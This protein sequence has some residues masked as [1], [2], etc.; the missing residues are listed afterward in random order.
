[1]S[2]KKF[3]FL[4]DFSALSQWGHNR[5]PFF[6]LVD[7]TGRV[8][9][10]AIAGAGVGAQMGQFAG[11]AVLSGCK[12][13]YR[14]Y[15]ASHRAS[16]ALAMDFHSKPRLKVI[17][18]PPRNDT[19]ATIEALQRQLAQGNSYLVN[20]CSQTHVAL[21]AEL[22]SL[23]NQSAAPYTVWLEDQ[24]L[25][26][27]PEAFVSVMDNQISTTPMKGT[28]FDPQLLLADAKE[29]AEHATVVDLLRNDLGRVARDIKLA[30]YRYLSEI[31]Q[32]DG[33]TLFQTSSEI[34]GTMPAN[35]RSEIGTWLP[36]LLPAGSVTGAP[37]TETLA[38][39]H[40]YEAEPRGF[41]TGIAVLF[42]G[43]SLY[44]CVLIRF[45]DLAAEILC[46]R[47]GAGITIYSDA[48]QE[49]EEILNKV[50]IPA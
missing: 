22:S 48:A 29:Q 25:A 50:Y 26:F 30:K 41:F 44:S 15:G 45:L 4:P 43:E 17:R 6:A 7:F 35:W 9:A 21:D 12:L 38:L 16:R 1:M 18:P 37:K 20:Y 49:Y 47:S 2:I 27:S 14:F 28:G 39:I 24:F 3:N 36:R 40:R 46:F 11:E 19:I 42:D 31:P 32:A 5:Q 33:R 13:R 34:T 23:Y 10:T 8:A